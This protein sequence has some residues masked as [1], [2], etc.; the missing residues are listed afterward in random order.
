MVPGSTGV[1]HTKGWVLRLDFLV[2]GGGGG[3][4]MVPGSTGLVHD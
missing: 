2:P 4:G 3:G 1:I